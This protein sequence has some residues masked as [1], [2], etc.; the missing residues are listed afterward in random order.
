MHYI[1]PRKIFALSFLFSLAGAVML[2][3]FDFAG[4]YNHTQYVESW[5][6]I[7]FYEATPVI[8]FLI[9]LVVFFLFYNMI[10]SLKGLQADPYTPTPKALKLGMVFAFLAFLMVLIGFIVFEIEMRDDP[11]T[12]WW[13]GEG[14]YGGLFG[15]LLTF[16]LQYM[17]YRDLRHLYQSEYY[18]PP[19]PPPPP[20]H[21]DD[22][23]K[24]DL[25]DV[26][27]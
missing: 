13:M 22:S 23:E 19:P 6:Y 21:K 14:F 8:M 10:I 5:S 16:I 9:I 18:Q 26:E 4:W 24:M 25:W 2:M 3:A 20:G 12:N 11:P 1:K 15:S 7:G 17:A 27:E